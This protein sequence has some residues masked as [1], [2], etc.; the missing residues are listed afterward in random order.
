M[1][2]I[3]PLVLAGAV[4]AVALLSGC[5]ADVARSVS[6]S[7][8]AAA[9]ISAK[10]LSAEDVSSIRRV[11]SSAS[12]ILA[13]GALPGMPDVVRLSAVHGDAYCRQLGQLPSDAVPPTTDS[14][15]LG[16]LSRPPAYVVAGAAVAR[17]SLPVPGATP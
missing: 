8:A 11:C 1:L 7:A 12:P 5:S 4:A 10:F 16:W 13:A 17:V 9:G 3:A 2:R 15:T 6:P 14:G